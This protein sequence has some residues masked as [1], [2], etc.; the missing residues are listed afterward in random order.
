[1]LSCN[2]RVR[3]SF[4][5]PGWGGYLLA[6]LAVTCAAT[7]NA[8]P[9]T[10]WLAVNSSTGGPNTKPFSGAATSSPV[11]GNGASGSAAQVAIYAD[12]AG[13]FDGEADIS[14]ENGERI[15]LT[16]SVTLEG[17]AGSQEQFRWGLFYEN[18]APTVP[19]GWLGYFATNSNSTS[20]GNMRAKSAGNTSVFIANASTQVLDQSID[21]DP[22]ANG[23]YTYTMSVSRYGSE[24]V[25]EASLA[26]PGW[27]QQWS[28]STS[29]TSFRTF[30]FNRVGFLSGDGMSADRVSFS[31]VAVV[32]EAIPALTL[33]VTTSGANIG[34]MRLVNNLS[35]EVAIEYYEIHSDQ[36]SLDADNWTS[37]DDQEGADPAGIGWVE[38]GG[39]DATILSEGV[40]IGSPATVAAGESLELG[41]SFLAGGDEDLEVYVGLAD[42]SFLR[43]AVEYVGSVFLAGDY[44]G[45]NVV[46]AADYV[47]WRKFDPTGTQNYLDWVAHF[48]DSNL[49][50]GG[51]QAASAGVPEPMTASLL[52]LGAIS[53]L[54]VVRNLQRHNIKQML[55]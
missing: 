9:V 35:T 43:G 6:L 37:L 7:G 52:M 1:M 17:I 30:N 2:Q 10:D 50:S 19:T 46:D 22:W 15:T 47:L 3:R 18:A 29:N 39:S 42:G 38:G 12:I 4:S 45:D 32:A 40:V 41:H 8:A 49:G 28:A 5:A 14:L 21:G 26:R 31:N 51:A 20:G 34:M 48:G 33:E 55:S 11:I 13:D 54:F 44:N 25:I 24:A 53:T 27:S 16:G 23:T 36:G